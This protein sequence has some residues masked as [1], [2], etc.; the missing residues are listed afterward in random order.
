ML[1]YRHSY[2]AG[3]FADV[4]KHIVLIECLEHFNKKPTPFDYIDTHA[5]AG[6]YDLRSANANKTSEYKEGIGK[7]KRIDFPELS[8][9]IFTVEH[10]TIF[11]KSKSDSI[12]YEL[13][14]DSMYV[15]SALAVYV[16]DFIEYR[17]LEAESAMIADSL[18]IE[19]E[20]LSMISS[21]SVALE[22]RA[23]S[24][25]RSERIIAMRQSRPDVSRRIAAIERDKLRL[26]KEL[27]DTRNEMASRTYSDQVFDYEDEALKGK[28]TFIDGTMKFS[29][30]TKDT[31]IV[32]EKSK[33]TV[34]IDNTRNG[35]FWEDWKFWLLIGGILILLIIMAFRK[36]E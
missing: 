12:V 31:S 36:K 24:S 16:R 30:E 34:N 17:R 29:Y 13:G 19:V 6:L 33:T 1:S 32:Y 14:L 18:G 28:F 5:G 20:E 4:L 15:D 35:D 26:A 23:I 7:L 11:I 9:S 22:S 8:D 2:H 21:E 25:V 27:R 3:N 10:D